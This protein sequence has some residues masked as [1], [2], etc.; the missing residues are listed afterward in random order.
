MFTLDKQYFITFCIGTAVRINSFADGFYFLFINEDNEWYLH[1]IIKSDYTT[2][3]Q[4]S[5]EQSHSFIPVR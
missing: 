5:S 1:S 3:K 2:P 4:I